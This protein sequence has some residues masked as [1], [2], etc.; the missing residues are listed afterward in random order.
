MNKQ[1]VSL[2]GSPVSPVLAN[3]YMEKFED[4]ASQS[5]HSPCFG[6]VTLQLAVLDISLLFFINS[7]RPGMLQ[8]TNESSSLSFLEVLVS[9]KDNGNLVTENQPTQTNF[10]ISTSFSQEICCFL[11]SPEY[12]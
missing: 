8:F 7:L 9:R 10:Q 12:M 2:G 3:I 4:Q 11:H 5:L 6:N 1:R